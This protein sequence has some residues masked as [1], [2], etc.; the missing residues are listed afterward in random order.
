[1]VPTLLPGESGPLDETSTGRVTF[2]IPPSVPVPGTGSKPSAGSGGP[3]RFGVPDPAG[4]SRAGHGEQAVRGRRC[5]VEFERSAGPEEVGWIATEIKDIRLK[6]GAAGE[7]DATA[8]EGFDLGCYHARV[9]GDR[10][11]S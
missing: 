1:M 11:R 8:G 4:R 3:G 6:G 7:R 5:P 2:P 10:K 9:V